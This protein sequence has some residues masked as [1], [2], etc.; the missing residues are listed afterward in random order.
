[1]SIDDDK[2]KDLAVAYRQL[3]DFK[4]FQVLVTEMEEKVEELKESNQNNDNNDLRTKGIVDGIRFVLSEPFT[5]VEQ[6]D[7][8][9]TRK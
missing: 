9:L 7:D 1:M 5:V 8:T 2:L 3:L 4:P 6:F